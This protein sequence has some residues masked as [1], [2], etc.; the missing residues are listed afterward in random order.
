MKFANESGS[1]NLLIKNDLLVLNCLTLLD[2]SRSKFVPQVMFAIHFGRY[3]GP[4]L[5]G[6]VF[7]VVEILLRLH[8]IEL[9]STL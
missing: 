7:G 2:D 1:Y 6:H 5:F 3:S 8:S 9:L 4:R